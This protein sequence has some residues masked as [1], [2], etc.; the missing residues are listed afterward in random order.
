MQ[1]ILLLCCCLMTFLMAAQAGSSTTDTLPEKPSIACIIKASPA[2]LGEGLAGGM[3]QVEI[4]VGKAGWTINS[5]VRA[6]KEVDNLGVL[7][8][9]HLRLEAQ[10]RHYL[11]QQWYGLYIFPFVNVNTALSA[12]AGAGL[13]GQ[14]QIWQWLGMDM[15]LSVQNSNAVDPYDSR[16]YLRIQ[17]AATFSISSKTKTHDR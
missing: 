7:F 4:P 12:G 5:S 3:V 9:A 1:R 11:T 10:L 13:G 14:F 15:N 2:L 6:R 17:A 8:P 16:F